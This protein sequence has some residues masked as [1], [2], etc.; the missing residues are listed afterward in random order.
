MEGR[1]KAAIS[2]TYLK[3]TV[4]TFDSSIKY[5]TDDDEIKRP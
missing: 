2:W 3:I 1:T 5:G 4:G